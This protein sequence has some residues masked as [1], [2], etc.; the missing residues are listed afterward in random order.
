MTVET[1]GMIYRSPEF[2][3]FMRDQGHC[4]RIVANDPEP[5]LPLDGLDIYH[6]PYPEAYYL[7]RV[8]RCWNY[9]VRS[10]AADYVCLVNSDNA[11]YGE[12]KAPLIALLDGKTLPCSKIVEPLLLGE[13]AEVVQILFDKLLLDPEHFNWDVWN[14]IASTVWEKGKVKDGGMYMPSIL[15]RASFLEVGG[16]PEGNVDGVSADTILFEK[17][18]ELGFRHVTCYESV[19]FNFLEGEMRYTKLI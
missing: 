19:V 14:G 5:R 16:F 13:N 12:W 17:L 18:K 7:E 2:L 4:D 10:S 9:C 3:Q 8:Y 11:F 15:H 6:D 1:V